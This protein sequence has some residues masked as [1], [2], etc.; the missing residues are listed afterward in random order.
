MTAMLLRAKSKSEP[1]DYFRE[2]DALGKQYNKLTEKAG[3]TAQV[4]RCGRLAESDYFED[5]H[6]PPLFTKARAEARK[7]Q[8]TQKFQ[9]Y[10]RCLRRVIFAVKDENLI[11]ELISLERKLGVL[12]LRSFQNDLSEARKRLN[13]AGKPE[14]Y[15]GFVA[16]VG[17]AFIVAL[18]WQ[19]GGAMG[20]TVAAVFAL[21]TAL[22]A[23]HELEW[24]R[25]RN[26]KR[27]TDEVA[28]AEATVNE[29]VDQEVFIQ[30]EE[31]TGEA[32]EDFT[33]EQSTR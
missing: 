5:R 2:R 19:F 3:I 7:L 10:R 31:D 11:C 29:I 1:F 17:G 28:E 18:G 4:E 24:S 30:V 9:S 12:K 27:A 33:R 16:G 22:Y 6:L 32:D 26:I 15:S 20:G 13:D 23:L 8:E 25:T 14:R 21:I